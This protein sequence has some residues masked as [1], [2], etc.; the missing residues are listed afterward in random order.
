V[1]ECRICNQEVARSNLSWG[2]FAPRSTQPS[3]PLESVNEYQLWLGRQRQVW[4]IPIAD[5]MQVKLWYPSTMRAIPE[6]LRDVLCIDAIQVNAYLLT[7]S[8]R[9]GG[10]GAPR[11]APAQACNE[12][13]SSS[14]EPGRPT[15]ARSANTRHPAGRPHTPPADWIYLPDVRQHHRLMPHGRGHKNVKHRNLEV[16]SLGLTSTRVWFTRHLSVS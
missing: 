5:E 13:C 7:T 15:W 10:G 12:A 9:R 3:I 6:C 4:L 11:Y 14:L 8:C 2:H 16:T 1:V